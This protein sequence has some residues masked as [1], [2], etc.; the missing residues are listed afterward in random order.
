VLER[1]S[2]WTAIE[3]VGSHVA[4]QNDN[5]QLY[6]RQI[7]AIFN[8][9]KIVDEPQDVQ[10]IVNYYRKMKFPL[11]LAYDR[12]GFYHYG[13]SYDGKYKT[14]D[15]RESPRLVEKCMHDIN[16]KN[17]LELAYGRGTNTAFLARRNPQVAFEAVDISNKPLR[18]YAALP[19]AHF[20]LCDFHDLRGLRDTSYDLAFVIEALSCSTDKPRVL[21]EVKKKLK[22]DGLLIVIDGY[23][24][25]RTN[26]L[27]PSEQIMW[28]LIEK[29]LSVENIERVSV[30][31]NYMRREYSIVAS[32]DL[33]LHVIPSMMRFVPAARFYFSHPI[34]ARA[35][36]AFLPF[37]VVKNSIF[38]LLLPIAMR[39]Q[40]ACHYIH[41]LRKVE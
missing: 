31:E 32:K 8:V 20:Q 7:G 16:A 36:N 34:L 10:H 30:V 18:G 9:A 12:D 26:P 2:N 3:K 1:T 21:H 40:I 24:R 11:L 4:E 38:V 33:S 15:L 35:V 41:V 14:D 23:Q 39:R 5:L 27:T 25:D 29:S 37:D 22:P 17:V 13:I 28:R 6:L 19:N